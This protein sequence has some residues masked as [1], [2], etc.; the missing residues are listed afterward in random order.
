MVINRF[1]CLCYLFVH[2]VYLFVCLRS[3]PF[4]I[5]RCCSDL[6]TIV[7]IKLAV[8]D[9]DIKPDTNGSKKAYSAHFC[10]QIFDSITIYVTVFSYG[11]PNV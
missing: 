8:S 1:I 4:L 9:I 10:I 6:Y 11:T 2:V 5:I 3:L 7:Q